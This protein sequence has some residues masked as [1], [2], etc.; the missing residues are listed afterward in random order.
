MTPKDKLIAFMKAKAQ[1]LPKY[2]RQYFTKKDEAAIRRW[3]DED[4]EC[5]L[6]ELIR[7]LTIGSERHLNDYS[8]CAFCVMYDQVCDDC[9][10]GEH[11]GVCTDPGSLYDRLCFVLGKRNSITKCILPHKEELLKLLT[12]EQKQ[13]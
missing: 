2:K 11:H 13:Y 7:T 9:P 3:D 10:Y 4:A 8:I 12:E 6:Q 5:V 1:Y